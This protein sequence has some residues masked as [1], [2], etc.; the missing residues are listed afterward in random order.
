M[1]IERRVINLIALLGISVFL[2]GAF[3]PEP[4]AYTGNHLDKLYHAM[5]FCALTLM[6]RICFGVK[7]L[8]YIYIPLLLALGVEAGQG[9]LLPQR[10]AETGDAL[11]NIVGIFIAWPLC[12]YLG[13]RIVVYKAGG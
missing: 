7:W 8:L 2:L 12:Y 9:W 1:R 6:F 4:F 5:A 10:T 11:A 13:P 3:R